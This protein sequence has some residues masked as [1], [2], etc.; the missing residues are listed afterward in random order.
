MTA[1]LLLL[2]LLL[3][4]I[5]AA[6][7]LRA[8]A[9]PGLGANRRLG[10]I[11]AYGFGAREETP[12]FEPRPATGLSRLAEAIGRFAAERLGNDEDELRKELMAAGLYDL[13]PTSFLGY[14][15]LSALG[16]A[17]LF[18]WLTVSSG[19][20][21][22]TAV[23]LICAVTASGWFGPLVYIR[24]KARMRFEEIEYDLPELVD[25][26]VVIIEAGLGLSSAMQLASSRI[27][28]PLGDELRLTLQEQRM[29]LSTTES[30]SNML[31]RC[32]T[33][34]MR[35]FVRSILQGETL[36]VSIGSIMRNLAHDMR[37]R[38][39]QA[40]EQRAQK[41]PIKILF[42]LVFFIFPPMFIVLLFPA[43]YNF[44]H[45]FGGG[46]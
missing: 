3:T 38:R 9:L 29:G 7:G 33:P 15:A 42:P 6:L 4:G 21:P 36:G 25:L 32:E 24:R 34:S 1:I 28:G 16:L 44:S 41:A 10:Q 26:L 2:G 5:A 14:R 37:I 35:S 8:A 11:R 30:L 20:T 46:V 19:S 12:E 40:A 22:L 17:G 43:V 39:R 13:S 27:T 18:G 45:T 31:V 23:V